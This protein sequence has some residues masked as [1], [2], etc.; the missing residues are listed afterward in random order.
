MT[1]YADLEIGLHHRDGR[2][3]R[4]ELRYS[5]PQTDADVRLDIDGP[6]V[7]AVDPDDLVALQ[8][9][10]EAYGRELGAALLTGRLGEAYRTAVATS[11]AHG[12]TL[13]VRLLVGPSA[14]ALHA[15][16]WETMRDPRDGAPLLTDENIVFSRYLSSMD[17]R[18][19]GVLPKSSLRALVI[20]A[21]PDDVAEYGGDRALS[22][23]DVAEEVERVR[24]GLGT[25]PTRT[26]AGREATEERLFAELRDGCDVLHLVCHGYLVGAGESVLLLCD[27]DGRAAPVTGSALVERIRDLART[28][29][30]IVLA[31]CQSAGDTR[32]RHSEDGGVMAA[33]GP[34]LAEAGV[35]AVLAMQGDVSMTTIARFMP[36][37]LREL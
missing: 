29:R 13:R 12:A 22:A 30:L 2:T 16:R 1:D 23:V 9:D 11:Q 34:R 17:W 24:E 7:A 33:L 5:Q 3:W 31:S 37:F 19:V 36:T 27:S 18:P 15:V 32:D 8:D 26:L 6:L 28:P 14:A 25:L 4:V 35:P 10:E 20:V 21:G